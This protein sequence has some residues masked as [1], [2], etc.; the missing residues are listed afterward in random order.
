MSKYLQL[1][2]KN[3]N[4]VL[5]KNKILSIRKI[6]P[7]GPSRSP[8]GSYQLEI[9]HVEK[10]YEVYKDDNAGILL[11]EYQTIGKNT[12]EF[13]N[14]EACNKALN[15]IQKIIKNNFRNKGE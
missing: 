11:M 9:G 4:Y 2:A 3:R 1:L 15:I 7:K 12:M 14:E 13:D 6:E 10:N 8:P 5:T